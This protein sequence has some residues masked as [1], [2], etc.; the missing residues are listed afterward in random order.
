MT[1]TGLKRAATIWTISL[2]VIFAILLFPNILDVHGF[3]RSVFFTSLGVGFIWLISFA[4]GTLVDGVVKNELKKR[5]ENN[6]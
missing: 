1:L 4:V 6:R 3:W 5:E 2:S